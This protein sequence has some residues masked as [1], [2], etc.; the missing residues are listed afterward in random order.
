MH[1]PANCRREFD[2]GK[3]VLVEALLHGADPHLAALCFP[4][5][6]V[7]SQFKRRCDAAAQPSFEFVS[8]VSERTAWKGK[9]R[10]CLQTLLP[11]HTSV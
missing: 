9:H 8:E 4:G 5:A 6:E 2:A 11:A 10:P 7:P 1:T 3:E